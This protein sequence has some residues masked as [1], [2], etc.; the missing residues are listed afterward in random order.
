MDKR[1][2]KKMLGKVTNPQSE[3]ILIHKE[4]LA[5][6]FPS[7]LSSLILKYIFLFSE[8]KIDCLEYT[9]DSS[10]T[11]MYALPPER[12]LCIGHVDAHPTLE[13]IHLHSLE[14]QI[15]QTFIK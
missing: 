6:L 1:S 5:I 10:Y 9:I 14:C 12:V 4:I 13:V 8:P 15:T 11:D 7:V 2:S 3:S